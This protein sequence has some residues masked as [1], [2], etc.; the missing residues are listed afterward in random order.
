MQEFFFNFF[1]LILVKCY[2]GEGQVEELVF[3]DGEA[4]FTRILP[5]KP[6]SLKWHLVDKS[7]VTKGLQVP[8][9]K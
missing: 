9:E 1:Y 7:F 2:A 8:L 6:I 5:N 4:Y 3:K